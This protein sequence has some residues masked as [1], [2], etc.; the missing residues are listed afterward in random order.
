[1]ASSTSYW[2]LYYELITLNRYRLL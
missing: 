2:L 1:M